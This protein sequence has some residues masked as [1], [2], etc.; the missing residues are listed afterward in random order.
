M[1]NHS[2]SSGLLNRHAHTHTHTHT[3]TY[4][5]HTDREL[6][7]CE[8]G[9]QRNSNNHSRG[10]PLTSS[11]GDWTHFF[12]Q[13]KG[14]LS[15]P[16]LTGLYQAKPGVCEVAPTRRSH[17]ISVMESKGCW[18]QFVLFLE[19]ACSPLVSVKPVPITGSHSNKATNQSDYCVNLEADLHN[20]REWLSQMYST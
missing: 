8:L 3:H 1:L 13:Q 9:R 2:R 16:H 7:T 10:S 17:P 5:H 11:H 4:I 6:L 14:S 12:T 18:P 15:A 19:A 20:R